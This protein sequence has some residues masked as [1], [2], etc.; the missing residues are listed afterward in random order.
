MNAFKKANPVG[1]ITLNFR[2]VENPDFYQL[3]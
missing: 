2:K 3:L 1:L